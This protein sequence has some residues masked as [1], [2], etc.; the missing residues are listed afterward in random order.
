MDWTHSQIVSFSPLLTCNGNDLNALHISKKEIIGKIEQ[1]GKSRLK[2]KVY[3]AVY[4]FLLYIYNSF[5]TRSGALKHCCIG[6][7]E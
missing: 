2:L 7:D 3:V 5:Y 1:K 4:T 6:K